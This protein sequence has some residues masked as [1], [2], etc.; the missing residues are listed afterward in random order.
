MNG[1]KEILMTLYWV[2]APTEK[3]VDRVHAQII[4]LIIGELP[5]EREP[6]DGEYLSGSDEW[7]RGYNYILSQLKTILN[8]MKGE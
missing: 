1:L 3:D 6:Q 2:E 7:A 8:Q 4:D 5:K